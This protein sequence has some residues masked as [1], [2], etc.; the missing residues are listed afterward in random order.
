MPIAA[1]SYS[2]TPWQNFTTTEADYAQFQVQLEPSTATPSVSGFTINY[3]EITP[4]TLSVTIQPTTTNS[5]VTISI[6]SNKPL[7]NASAF[8]IQENSSTNITLQKNNNYTLTGEYNVIKGADGTA[9]V[10]IQGWDYYGNKG[11]ANASFEVDTTPPSVYAEMNQS[12]YTSQSTASGNLTTSKPATV[13]FNTTNVNYQNGVITVQIPPTPDGYYEINVTA[14]DSLGNVNNTNILIPIHNPPLINAIL[15]NSTVP[16]NFNVSLQISVYD[17]NSTTNEILFENK[18]IPIN[19]TYNFSE[20]PGNYSFIIKSTDTYNLSS[21]ATLNFTVLN[22]S[23][24]LQTQYS[25]NES[26]TIITGNVTLE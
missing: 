1:A 8:I 16:E 20:T 12:F 18:S 15:S 13:Y 11:Y 9:K 23:A 24:N 14:I 7:E 17:S 19:N 3:L 4:P 21:N 6:Q 25:C 2:W 5:N 26:Q 10:N 22:E